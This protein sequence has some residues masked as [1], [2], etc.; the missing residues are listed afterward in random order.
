M[1]LEPAAETSL[2][3]SVLLGPLLG[4]PLVC[5]TGIITWVLMTAVEDCF[6]EESN[7]FLD[8]TCTWLAV[9]HNIT[10]TPSSFVGDGPE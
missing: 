2:K 3:N 1:S 9:E 4:S 8:E 10:I 5:R 7:L 6:T